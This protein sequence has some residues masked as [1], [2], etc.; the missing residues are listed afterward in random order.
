MKHHRFED[1]SHSLLRTIV[2]SSLISIH[3]FKG[4]LRTNQVLSSAGLRWSIYFFGF[5]FNHSFRS[6]K[7]ITYLIRFLFRQ[8]NFQ[9]KEKKERKKIFLS[10]HICWLDWH[11]LQ[12]YLLSLR[13]YTRLFLINVQ[14]G[15]TEINIKN[16]LSWKVR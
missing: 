11:C 1:I 6:W 8:G 15:S 16:F 3:R 7:Q 2:L 9:T 4:P 10:I 12:N 13:S 14:P 5:V